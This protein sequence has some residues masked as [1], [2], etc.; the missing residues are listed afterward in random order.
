M[1]NAPKTTWQP[2]RDPAEAAAD[3]YKSWALGI[4]AVREKC[5]RAG[6]VLPRPGDAEEAR[7]KAEGV[8]P[9]SQMKAAR[10]G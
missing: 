2:S 8:V 3:S 7:W 1:S 6:S 4:K 9:P 5:I 10:D